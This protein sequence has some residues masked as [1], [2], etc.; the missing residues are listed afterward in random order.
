MGK[1][2]EDDTF[3]KLR[4]DPNTY[5]VIRYLKDIIE[6]VERDEAAE[7]KKLEDKE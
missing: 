3:D 4:L 2:D 6:K 5:G 7:L 1:D